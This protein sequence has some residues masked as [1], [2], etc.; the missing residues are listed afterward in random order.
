LKFHYRYLTGW[1][2]GEKYEEFPSGIAAKITAKANFIFLIHYA[3][4]PVMESDS[5]VFIM[6]ITR[7]KN[8]REYATFSLH[9]HSDVQGER[10][11]I[12]AGQKVTL[13]ASKT[14]EE[15]L[16]AFAVLAHA[17]HLA[18]AM[19]AYCITPQQDT[20]PLLLID[21]WDFNWQFL[22]KFRNYE[23]L[24]AGSVVH[25]FVAYDNTTDNPEN[26][27]N[28]PKDVSYSFDADQEMMEFFIYH[29]PYR[30]GDELLK[31]EYPDDSY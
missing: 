13:H 1:L 23:K 12:P 17:H 27:N 7:E 26:P 19:K 6:H 3:P 2:P 5:S 24:P 20:I 11:F 21:N 22:Y 25:F 10:F 18:R 30:D 15:D 29:V 8:L 9:G 14:I 28:P 16:S 31:I 4:Y